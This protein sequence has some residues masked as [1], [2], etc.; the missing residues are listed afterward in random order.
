[1]TGSSGDGER[2]L[3]LG[4]LIPG[5]SASEDDW[6]LP[7]ALDLVRELAAIDDVR[8]FALRH[9]PRRKRYR[10]FGAEVVT[11]GDDDGTAWSRLRRWRRVLRTIR[12]EHARRPFDV[13][14][15]IWAHEPGALA[16]RAGR[17]IGVPAVVSIFGG[18][19]V[20]L[21]SIS[22]GPR[23]LS[24][25]RL[26]TR[27]ALDRAA[28]VTAVARYALHGDRARVEPERLE[29]FPLGV[30]T[31]LFFP[32][33]AGRLEGSPALLNVASLVPVKGHLDL[34]EALARLRR[35]RP[36][37]VLHLVGEG[38]LRPRLEERARAADLAGSVRFHGDVRHD[39]LPAVYRGADL[40]VLSSF[41]EGQCVVAVES[42]A[43]GTPVAGTAVGILPEIV[44]PGHLAPAGDPA[45]LAR[46]VEAA[47]D[48]PREECDALLRSGRGFTL[49]ESIARWR[50][51]LSRA[52]AH[53][54]RTGRTP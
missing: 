29:V 37:A 38:P 42:I 4:I 33:P 12:E 49:P 10:V 32:A 23:P 50:E 22:Y 54:R 18:E 39:A 3:R 13:L 7:Y 44:P 25:S 26:L 11:F 48:A 35:T 28:R 19:L 6:C 30:D 51:V 1:M 41:S 34:L 16:V 17:T 53:T 24:A 43:C 40:F 46:A 15:G 27:Y 45:A 20:R 2:P 31:R 21:P 5:F 52:A 9:P 36:G 47:L 14:H 8:V